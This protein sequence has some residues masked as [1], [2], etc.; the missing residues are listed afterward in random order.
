MPAVAF[1]SSW[2]P[3]V[4]IGLQPWIAWIEGHSQPAGNA[5]FV[6]GRHSATGSSGFA[7][8]SSLM[9][10]RYVPTGAPWTCPPAVRAEMTRSV[11][12][13]VSAC[14]G[15]AAQSAA[16][17]ASAAPS[18]RTRRPPSMGDAFILPLLSPRRRWGRGALQPGAKVGVSTAIDVESDVGV[19]LSSSIGCAIPPRRAWRRARRRQTSGCWSRREAAHN[20]GHGLPPPE[21]ASRGPSVC[22]PAR[23]ICAATAW[24]S[25]LAGSPS[26]ATAV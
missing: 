14:A 12:W 9:S 22:Q 18:G 8:L 19:M 15:P 10:H 16:S 26:A 5:A 6:A 13:L 2:S 7:E 23:P 17:S 11:R 4:T 1:R 24:N 3:C 21:G 20:G 25:T